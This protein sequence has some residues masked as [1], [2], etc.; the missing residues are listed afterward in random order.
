ML[1]KAQHSGLLIAPSQFPHCLLLLYLHISVSLSLSP[2]PTPF[3]STSFICIF[4][5]VPLRRNSRGLGS[6]QS[7]AVYWLCD[8]QQSIHFTLFPYLMNREKITQTQAVVQIK[9]EGVH[10]APGTWQVL[11]TPVS[12]HSL[13]AYQQL[14]FLLMVQCLYQSSTCRLQALCSASLARPSTIFKRQ[15]QLAKECALPC[16]GSVR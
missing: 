16:W 15:A 11:R 7:L 9:Q 1:R 5:L 8:I 2:P 10:K 3:L 4:L 12:L 14:P 6:G 13:A